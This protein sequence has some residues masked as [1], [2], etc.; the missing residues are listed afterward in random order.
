M[1]EGHSITTWTNIGRYNIHMWS[2][3]STHLV[4]ENQAGSILWKISTIVLSRV[5][6]G[7]KNFVYTVIECPLLILL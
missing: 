6:V 7:G 3:E 2:V 1:A 5:G 4:T